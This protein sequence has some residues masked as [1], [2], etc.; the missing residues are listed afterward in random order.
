MARKSTKSKS[1]TTRLARK[2]PEPLANERQS[3]L[4]L[5]PEYEE[6]M[7]RYALY[8]EGRPKL[9]P[10]EFDKLDDE[11]LEL[12]AVDSNRMTDDQI[13][14]LQELEYLLIDTE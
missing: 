3:E 9:A 2:Q 4:P 11:L 8:G 13:V 5:T 6:Y 10:Q 12:L 7:E 1:R 14:R